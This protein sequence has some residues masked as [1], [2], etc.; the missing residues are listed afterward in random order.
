VGG[1]LQQTDRS[2]AET[3]TY[4]GFYYRYEALNVLTG[5]MEPTKI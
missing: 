2:G 5:V 3:R 4:L 1:L